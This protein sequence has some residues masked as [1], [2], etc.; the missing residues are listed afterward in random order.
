LSLVP[1][2]LA[3]TFDYAGAA[4]GDLH[5]SNPAAFPYEAKKALG[6]IGTVYERILLLCALGGA[7]R[8]S[9]EPESRARGWA[10]A[11][12][13]LVG[14]GSGFTLHAWIAYVAFPAA[15]LL[16]GRSLWRGPVLPAAAAVVVLSTIAVHAVFFGA[17]RYSMVV[18]P[19]LAALAPLA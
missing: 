15:A 17:G 11:A 8:G 6:A 10:R 12:I 3:A 1:R 19:L 7:A 5:E 2:K 18:F 13:A 4:G 14:G 9:P 16:R